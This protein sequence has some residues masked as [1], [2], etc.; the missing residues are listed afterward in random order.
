MICFIL[1]DTVIVNLHEL[2]PL[3]NFQCLVWVYLLS[4]TLLFFSSRNSVYLTV[5]TGVWK[6]HLRRSITGVSSVTS[7]F[8]GLLH[9]NKYLSILTIV[10]FHYCW[11][12]FAIQCYGRT[13]LGTLPF[14]QSRFLDTRVQ[15][16]E[17]GILFV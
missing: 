11:D 10:K 6:R 7:H 4:N 14:L 3:A 8:A 16:V 2:Q 5:L 17:I 15:S 1:K 13:I 12:L 9:L